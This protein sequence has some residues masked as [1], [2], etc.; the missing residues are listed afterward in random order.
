MSKPVELTVDTLVFEEL[1]VAKL[2]RSWELP[3]L[4]L[5]V[6]TSW[7]L[8]PIDTIGDDGVTVIDASAFGTVRIAEPEIPNIVAVM[9]VDPT[10]KAFAKPVADTVATDVVEEVQATV[11]LTSLDDP[12]L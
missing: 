2:V 9:L 8:A 7:L 11:L 4:Y 12:S 3:S 5:P 6:A 1:H 10:A